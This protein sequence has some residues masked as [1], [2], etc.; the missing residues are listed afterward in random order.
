V[1]GRIA[2]FPAAIG[3]AALLT[4]LASG[5][6]GGDSDTQTSSAPF[7]P[8]ATL[9]AVGGTTRTEKPSFVLDVKARKGDENLKSVA[10]ELPPVVLVDTTAIGAICTRAELQADGCADR[11][12]LGTARVLSPSYDGALAGNVYP[13]T[14]SSR[15]PKLVFMLSGP[16]TIQLEGRIVS[17]AGRIGAEVSDIP[18]TPLESFRF[19]IDGGKPGYL[20]LSR[21]ICGGD[22]E[23]DATFT[24]QGGQVVKRKVPLEG[25]CG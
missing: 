22:P 17:A 6:G 11:K 5:C 7:E 4:L 3:V 2:P 23:A 12:R 21:N 13:V 20:V 8:E 10:F 15:L 24:S 1:R 16:A 14:G 25:E 19:T 18:D 9:E